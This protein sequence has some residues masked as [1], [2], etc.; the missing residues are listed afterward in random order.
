MIKLDRNGTPI[1]PVT[2]A[3]LVAEVGRL[4]E[5][6]ADALKALRKHNKVEADVIG[7]ALRRKRDHWQPEVGNPEVDSGKHFYD[8]PANAGKVER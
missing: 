6:L 3:E 1:R 8:N 7:I 4:R 2:K 5:N